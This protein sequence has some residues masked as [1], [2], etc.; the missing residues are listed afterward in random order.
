MY[1]CRYVHDDDDEAN[2][3]DVSLSVACDRRPKDGRRAAARA[4]MPPSGGRPPC[5]RRA[6]AA[7]RRPEGGGRRVPLVL[8]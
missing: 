8:L 5:R 6:T 7:S 1:V 2:E 3:N 4:A